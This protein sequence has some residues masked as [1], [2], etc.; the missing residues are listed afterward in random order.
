MKRIIIIGASSGLGAR[1]AA[2]YARSGWKVGIAARRQKPLEQLKTDYPQQ[3]EYLTLDVTATDATGRFLELIR[4]LGGMDVLLYAAGTGFMDTSLDPDMT[5][6]TLSVNVIGLARILNAAFNYFRTSANNTPGHIAAITSVAGTKGIGVAAA[7]SASKRFGRTYID[8]LEQLAH[9]EH[10]NI[11]FTDIRPGFV[12]TPLLKADK[13]YPMIMSI[14]HAAPRIKRAID[15][16]RRVAVIDGRWK[17][18]VALW[19]L[20]PG[21][22]WRIINL[23]RPNH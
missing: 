12:R 14:D 16:G 23:N 10:V 5:D 6:A 3:I 17:I 15:R 18:L 20:I 13:S 8:A 1:L 4:I 9:T 7:Y 11:R 22:L 21:P 2:D 19:H